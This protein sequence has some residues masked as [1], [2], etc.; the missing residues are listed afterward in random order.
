MLIRNL[1]TSMLSN[2]LSHKITYLEF[3]QSE[4]EDSNNLKG[5][6]KIFF[7]FPLLINKKRISSFGFIIDKIKNTS[8]IRENL[9]KD[10]L[11]ANPSPN[12]RLPVVCFMAV[13]VAYRKDYSLIPDHWSSEIINPN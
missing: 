4:N 5:R 3:T 8:M 6:H 1:S 7:E 9:L 11:I 2:L 12:L 13:S 10:A